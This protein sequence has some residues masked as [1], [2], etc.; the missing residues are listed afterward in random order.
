MRHRSIAPT[1]RVSV[2]DALESHRSTSESASKSM[3][4]HWLPLWPRL[5]VAICARV[6]VPVLVQLRFEDGIHLIRPCSLGTRP[7]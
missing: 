4:H 2:R 5:A 3:S 7:T 1:H 6:L